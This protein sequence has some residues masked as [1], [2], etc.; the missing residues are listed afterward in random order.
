MRRIPVATIWYCAL[1]ALIASNLGMTVPWSVSL[2]TFVQVL[3]YLSKKGYVRTEAMLRK[4]SEPQTNGQPLTAQS[5]EAGGAKYTKAFELLRKYTEDNL[6][7]YRPELRKLLWPVFVYS[8]LDLVR[9]FY[10]KDAETFFL[11]RTRASLSATTTK[12]SRHFA[13]CDYKHICRRVE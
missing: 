3:E 9:D 4:E 1:G 2:L 12:T 11:R 10:T 13:K 6:D 5:T 7:L 8:F